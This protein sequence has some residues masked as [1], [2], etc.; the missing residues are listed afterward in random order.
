MTDFPHQMSPTYSE[1]AQNDAL[2]HYTT[3]DGLNGIFNS[4]EIWSTAYYCTNDESELAAGKGVLNSIFSEEIYRMINNKDHLVRTLCG[5][6]VDLWEY[7][8]KFEQTIISIAL[9]SLCAYI[10]CFCKPA[11]K[12]DFVNGLL[13][14]WRGYGVD[15]GY[16]L[17]FSRT[18]LQNAID[19]A[20]DDL[21]LN[22]ALEDVH[23]SSENPF[24][25]TALSHTKAFLQAYRDYL[26]ERGKSL[27]HL[28]KKE[29]VPNPIAGLLDGPLESLLDYLVN[30]KNTHFG[31]EKECR[32]SLVE[33]VS[34]D[35]ELLPT[36]YFNRGGLI[37]PY[38]KSPCAEF[39]LLDCIECIVVGP[40]ARMGDRVKSVC[41]MVQSK[42]LKIGVRP[43]NIPYASG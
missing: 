4:G 10:T 27:D 11:G 22:Y 30:T 14:Q 15:G 37:V 8:N 3:A 2:F 19:K 43:S 21:G 32:L 25:V 36:N 39:R 38:K 35:G 1:D 34:P 20:N 28:F 9:H 13:S 41:Q 12:E 7:P 33:G 40:H 5:S 18:K 42:G 26:T 23:Y 29:S 24:K 17:Q 31:E 16:A 6:E